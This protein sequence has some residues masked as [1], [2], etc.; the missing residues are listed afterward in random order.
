M[1][2]R[3]IVNPGDR[4]ISTWGNQTYDQT[5]QQYTSV[6]DRNTQWPTPLDGAMAY[7]T[8]TGTLWLRRSGAWKA[9]PLGWV[10]S[11]LGP[12]TQ[13]DVSALATVFTLS[14]S[15][16]AGRRYKISANVLASQ[17]T[18]SGTPGCTLNDSLGL[19]PFNSVRPIWDAVAAPAAIARIGSGFWVF[20]A[21]ATATDVFTLAGQST[22]GVLRFGANVS[23]MVLE[24][25]GM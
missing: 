10:A 24:D 17:Q 15:L 3:L 7:T 20:T 12:A 8:D 22:A 23:Q 16:T 1:A 13:T 4:I 25:L 21:T 9:L 11:Q 6:A 2:G 18:A 14:A 19:V 5:V